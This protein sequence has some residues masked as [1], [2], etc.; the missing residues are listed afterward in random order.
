MVINN[1]YKNSVGRKAFTNMSIG[2][3]MWST[4]YNNE[5]GLTN[6]KPTNE[7]LLNWFKSKHIVLKTSFFLIDTDTNIVTLAD[8]PEPVKKLS[9]PSKR[10]LAESTGLTNSLLYRTKEV[11]W[12][13][14]EGV[15][16]SRIKNLAEVSWLLLSKHYTL[17][18]TPV[19]NYTG[20]IMSLKENTIEN[21][22]RAL[23]KTDYLK[24]TY[25]GT[26]DTFNDCLKQQG[27]L[28]DVSTIDTLKNTITLVFEPGVRIHEYV[29]ITRSLLE[30]DD[31]GD[32]FRKVAKTAKMPWT[33]P[34]HYKLL[35][36]SPVYVVHKA[37]YALS[38]DNKN[39]SSNTKN[40]INELYPVCV[41][42]SKKHK[43]AIH[44]LLHMWNKGNTD[45]LTWHEL[46]GIIGYGYGTG[47]IVNHI[48]ANMML[49]FGLSPY[50][51][52][53]NSV[54][55]KHLKYKPPTTPTKPYHY[56]WD[57]PV[58]NYV[59]TLY[60]QLGLLTEEEVDSLL[61]HYGA[62]ISLPGVA[63]KLDTNFSYA[64]NMGE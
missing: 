29:T 40:N 42:D 9:I 26:S 23:V 7:E 38:Q 56:Y 25:K 19:A 22:K 63:I 54:N 33:I 4:A 53:T 36:Q 61:K 12:F 60:L 44:Y 62:K 32:K 24:T 17:S 11:H 49:T 58:I 20:L 28:C 52:D 14:K 39:A 30:V 27:I 43:K 47:H 50:L 55:F 59:L 3:D 13:F 15:K 34:H 35:T 8:L 18:V 45:G 16:T 51:T 57:M 48:V 10:L 46:Y 37:L 2:L 31:S 1:K 21:I 6:N 5:H 41:K 64:V